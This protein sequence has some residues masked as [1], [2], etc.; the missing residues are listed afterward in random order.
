MRG[1]QNIRGRIIL[2]QVRSLPLVA[3][4]V[5]VTPSILRGCSRCPHRSYLCHRQFR[6]WCWLCPWWCT[7]DC[8]TRL[9]LLLLWWWLLWLVLLGPAIIIPPFVIV[10]HCELGLQLATVQRTESRS[11]QISSNNSNTWSQDLLFGSTLDDRQL[12]WGKSTH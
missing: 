11:T 6:H 7:S 1:Q 2:D 10:I 9:L 8:W 4:I 12:L 5:L 3:P